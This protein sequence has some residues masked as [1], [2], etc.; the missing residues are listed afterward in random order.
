MPS[1]TYLCKLVHWK[2]CDLFSGLKYDSIS[3]AEHSFLGHVFWAQLNSLTAKHSNIWLIWHCKLRI[4]CRV[5]FIG[6]WFWKFLSGLC[7]AAGYSAPVVK[8]L[9]RNEIIFF[10]ATLIFNFF[11]LRPFSPA[12]DWSAGASRPFPS[13]SPRSFPFFTALSKSEIFVC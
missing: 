8:P 1:I 4:V 7:T 12:V 10:W 13:T 9:K 11:S 5:L 2:G 6:V 3:T